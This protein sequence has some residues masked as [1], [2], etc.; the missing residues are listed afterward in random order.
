MFYSAQQR[1]DW[2]NSVPVIFQSAALPD[3]DCTTNGPACCVGILTNV[4]GKGT[5]SS[6]GFGNF[7][8]E[9]GL[10]LDTYT[11][12]RQILQLAK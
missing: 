5:G 9:S 12:L 4:C 11:M 3:V 1:L 7:A 10:V 6:F 2:S 8:A